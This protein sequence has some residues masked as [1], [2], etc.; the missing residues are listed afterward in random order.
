MRSDQSPWLRAPWW[1]EEDRWL[2]LMADRDLGNR[3]ARR[4]RARTGP[5]DPGAR[6]ARLD[7]RLISNGNLAWE[8]LSDAHRRMWMKCT[9]N[10]FYT[11]ACGRTDEDAWCPLCRGGQYD[12]RYEASWQRH[13]GWSHTS[14]RC[15]H[16]VLDGMRAAAHDRQVALLADAIAAG[17]H[18]GCH[19]W[20]DVDGRRARG[21]T[22]VGETDQ[23][24][25]GAQHT[26]GPPPERDIDG[27][28]PPDCSDDDSACDSAPLVAA[29]G[30]GPPDRGGGAEASPPA[31]PAH[32]LEDDG[33]RPRRVHR[34]RTVPDEVLPDAG[35]SPDGILLAAL[36]KARDVVPGADKMAIIFEV[37]M[38]DEGCGAGSG[39]LGGEGRGLQAATARKLAK[40][41]ALRDR[42]SQAGWQSAEPV[43]ITVGARGALPAY[44]KG[45]LSR[46]GVRGAL[47]R[48]LLRDMSVQ[49]MRDLALMM[50]T[51]RQLERRP[52]F[53]VF[54]ALS[55]LG[56][57]PATK[58]TTTSTRGPEARR[59][60]GRR[61]SP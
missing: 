21:P 3:G 59:R 50:Q 16:P 23:E 22:S 26:R 11:N 54:S 7:H 39:G 28:A 14:R 20:A 8:E 56:R 37:T 30:N 24:D 46:L 42:L 57:R 19:M 53:A 4:V 34:S 13:D 58:A 31:S 2:P 1:A 41:A 5:E 38:A 48:R 51:R 60:R 55:S 18:A 10:S 27:T 32:G 61:R 52:E 17:Q 36:P 47:A 6:A 12:S 25:P 45:E 33:P 49:A 44:T 9:F 40:L 43:V 35:C 29:G 15:L